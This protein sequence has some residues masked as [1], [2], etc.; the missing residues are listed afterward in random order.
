MAKND[1]IILRNE[2]FGGV[3]VMMI[4]NIEP[5][6][7][8]DDVAKALSYSDPVKAVRDYCKETVV[9]GIPNRNGIVKSF[10]FG[11]ISKIDCLIIKSDLSDAGVFRDWIYDEV[12]PLTYKYGA[13]RA[14]QTYERDL[15]LFGFYDFR[16]DM[17]EYCFVDTIQV[18]RCSYS[19]DHIVK[20]LQ[21]NGIEICKNRL[22]LWMRNNGYLCQSERTYNQPTQKAKNMGL[23]ELKYTT[24]IKD[25]LKAVFTIMKVTNKGR[26][27]FMK[28][29]SE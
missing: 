9:L 3:R 12:L 1:L 16:K 19:I 10:R 4:E 18:S 8:L 27:Y 14:M 29:L 26:I 24:M 23:F 17:T 28:K 2:Q 15:I 5:L 13:C 25:D 7:C 21:R 22:F 20:M 6:F 11:K